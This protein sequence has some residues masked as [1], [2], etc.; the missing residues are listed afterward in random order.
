M[1]SGKA[2][3]ATYYGVNGFNITFTTEL[4]LAVSSLVGAAG[5]ALA[6]CAAGLLVF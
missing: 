3:I 5:V 1:E 2:L 4:Q 6:T